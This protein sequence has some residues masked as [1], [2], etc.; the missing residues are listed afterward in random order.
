MVPMT[1]SVP[2]VKFSPFTVT[3]AFV[4]VFDAVYGVIVAIFGF[5]ISSVIDP[6]VPFRY[7]P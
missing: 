7:T 5:G 2:G 4:E 1:T 3:F 6:L